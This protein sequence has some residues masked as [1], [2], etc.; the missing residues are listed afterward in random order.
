MCT[1]RKVEKHTPI[2]SES[3]GKP[4]QMDGTALRNTF[5]A[6]LEVAGLTVDWMF[7]LNMKSN[8]SF[9]GTSNFISLLCWM[10][11]FFFIANNILSLKLHKTTLPSVFC[12]HF[13][14]NIMFYKWIIFKP[15]S[16]WPMYNWTWNFCYVS[17][18]SDWLCS[19]N[20]IDICM[21]FMTQTAKPKYTK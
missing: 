7:R 8:V 18:N 1:E 4:R 11:H 19:H 10:S 21:S 3:P 20:W 13:D 12:T 6:A 16:I 2:F 9:Y 17:T 15:C 14:T 5:P